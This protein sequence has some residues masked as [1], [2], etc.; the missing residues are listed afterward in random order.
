MKKVG[1]VVPSYNQG[2]FLKTCLDSL[3]A[4]KGVEVQIA[5]MDGGSTDETKQILSGY[6]SRCQYVRSRR[7]EGQ[8]AAINEGMLHLSQCEYVGWLNSDD[9]LAPEGLAQLAAALEQDPQASAAYGE[10][11]FWDAENEIIGKYPT[12]P[13]DRLALTKG[14]FICQPAT[15]IRREAWET[16][17]GLR[18]ELHMCM[19]YDLWW[20]LLKLGPLLYVPKIV[21][22]SRDYAATKTRSYPLRHVLE[23]QALLEEHN[24]NIPWNWFLEEVVWHWKVQN[25]RRPDR[26]EKVKL[27]W[28]T[29]LRWLYYR[30]HG[31]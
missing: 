29:G 16:L 18:E 28:K 3:L 14:C 19:D 20:R 2:R 15:L 1:I 13:F 31:L 11:Q 21:A 12:R 30:R 9:A 23:A 17:Q 8:S 7:D 26:Y 10:A 25:Q 27:L 24:G 4:Q 5:L 22:F 6:A